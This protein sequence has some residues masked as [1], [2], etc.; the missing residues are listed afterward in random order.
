MTRTSGNVTSTTAA[1]T[2]RVYG[3]PIFYGLI[4]ATAPE[5]IPPV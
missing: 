2:I 3:T 5:P 4:G 1:I